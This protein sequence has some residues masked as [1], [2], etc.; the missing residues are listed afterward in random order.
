MGIT[1]LTAD[2]II[3]SFNVVL[4]SEIY[5]SI[6]SDGI[7]IINML[8]LEMTSPKELE[9]EIFDVGNLSVGK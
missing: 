9:K 3:L 5:S 7:A 8:E 6:Y 2:I 4:C 1:P